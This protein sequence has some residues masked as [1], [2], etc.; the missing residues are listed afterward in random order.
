MRSK[1][2]REF[3]ICVIRYPEVFGD[4]K[5]HNYNI[6]AR[7]MENFFTSTEMQIEAGKQH[8]VLYVND[9]VDTLMKVFLRGERE[10]SYL[11][12]GS[13]YTERQLIEAV[14]TVIPGRETVIRRLSMQGVFAEIQDPYLEGWESMKSTAWRMV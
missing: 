7:L 6:C 8:R 2:S 9:A 12:P 4:Y 11:V 5:T 3:D 13:V 1:I 14:R 10:K